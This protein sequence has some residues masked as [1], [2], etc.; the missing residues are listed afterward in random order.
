MLEFKNRGSLLAAIRKDGMAICT[1]EKD[2]GK[3]Y[4]ISSDCNADELHQI[5]AKLEEL[6]SK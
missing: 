1:M 3:L 2:I 6:N 4:W 5:A